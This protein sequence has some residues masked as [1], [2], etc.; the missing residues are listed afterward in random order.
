[1][2]KDT[3]VFMRYLGSLTTPPC[4][5]VVIWTIFEVRLALSDKKKTCQEE[6]RAKLRKGIAM[7]T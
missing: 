1:M 5:E 4:D 2:P 6:N 7:L 3:D